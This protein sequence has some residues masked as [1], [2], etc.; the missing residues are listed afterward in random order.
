[1]SQA[2]LKLQLTNEEIE[3]LQERM[4]HCCRGGGS[5]AIEDKITEKFNKA[6]LGSVREQIENVAK[7]QKEFER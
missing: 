5:S 2:T 6:V 7:K 1:M 4:F 3:Y